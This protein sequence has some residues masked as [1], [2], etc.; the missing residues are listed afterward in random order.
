[1]RDFAYI[2]L[3][4]TGSALALLAAETVP[5]ARFA[6]D[7]N[8]V[9]QKFCT[10]CHDGETK[11]GGIDL[12]ALK[13]DLND[14]KS[15][16]TWVKVHDAVE[17]G[18]MPPPKKD[19]PSKKQRAEFIEAL[20]ETMVAADEARTKTVGRSV[21]RRLNRYEYENSLRDLLGAPWLQVKEMLPEDGEAH[22]F[23][24]VGEALDVSHVQ[25]ARY[26]QAAD[27]ALR[28]VVE[29]QAVRP[30]TTTNR[31]YARD[32]RSFVGKMKFSE[33][34][35]SPER[36]T[37]PLLNYTAQK[38]VLEEKAPVTVGAKNPAIREQEAMGVVASAY[39]PLEIKFSNFK[40]PVAGLYKLRISAY[41]FWAAPV[42]QARWWTPDR[43]NTSIGRRSEPVEIYAE[44]PPRL[45]RKLGGFDAQIEPGVHELEA[46]LLEGETVRPDPVRLFRS[47]PPAW[48]N[49]LATKEGQPGVAYRW[50]EVVGPIYDDKLSKTQ[51]LLFGDLPLK[52]DAKQQITVTPKNAKVDAERLLRNFMAQAYR[53][54]VVEEDVQRFLKVIN[55]A[56]A[57]G[58][59]FMDAMIAGYSGVLCSPGFVTLEEKPG[60]LD[61]YAL[62]SRLSYFLWNSAPDAELRSLAAKGKLNHP[63]TLR[64]QTE[65]LLN[66]PKA[67][68]FV[69]SFLD[70]WLDLRHA[71]AT[72][73]DATLYPDY[74]L[75]DALVEDA[76]DESQMFFAELLKGD[77]P[78]RNLIKS[79]FTMLNERL[80]KH[81][82][83]PP[84]EGI[85]LRRVPLP[86]N[87]VRGGL[88]TQA[89]VLKVTA[90]G[91]TTS[92]VLRGVWIM[93]RIIGKP[94][95]PPPPSVPAIEPD[96]RGAVTIR[97]QL[98]KHRNVAGCMNCHTK[99]DPA[100]F[101]LESFDVMGGWRTE[102][103]ALG[104]TNNVVPGYG[105]NGQPF[106][107]HPG[108]VVDAS[109]ELPN[110]G[111]K[112][113]DI[114]GLKELLLKDER[115]IARNLTRQLVVY[116][117]GAAVRFG[118]RAEVEEILDR[119]SSSHYGVR[120]VIQSIVQSDLFRNK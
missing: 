65:R 99:I 69:N 70:Y 52:V 90:N 68:K 111:G 12:T 87:S 108:P 47:R 53:R 3:V 76:V 63:D 80:A 62:A 119:A 21:W 32:Q 39:E 67:Q 13:F 93:E 8:P 45:L 97:E 85:H 61:D 96:T 18:E 64:A 48:K 17:S 109:G 102:Y 112:F 34:N 30:P 36:A 46:W 9:V 41:T 6:R 104:S 58:S 35:R 86:K 75:D 50:M 44:T 77:M 51:K 33:F 59:K 43:T 28:E 1:M 49:P 94:P 105:K 23:N 60:K 14:A 74:Y 79:D 78:S 4:L 92:P 29:A 24:K 98:D 91:T 95:P 88:M 100:G 26:L 22:R 89:S 107:F 71:S 117:T 16:A 20:A 38:D 81:Y 110:G 37:F 25:L 82:G 2:F 106:T 56:L 84:V 27:Y 54:P 40:A 5:A 72:S 42:S 73:P 83:L 7:I 19:Q 66:D 57:S 15:F 114:Q 113:Q 115:Q 55:T 10:D 118:D 101:A 31:Y 11:K 116:G 120:S 103:R